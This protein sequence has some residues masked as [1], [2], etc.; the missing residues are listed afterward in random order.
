MDLVSSKIDEI[1]TFDKSTVHRKEIKDQL[2]NS[3]NHL[4]DKICYNIRYL[5]TQ[6][7]SNLECSRRIILSGG[8]TLIEGLKDTVEQQL[9]SKVIQP[10][11]P[12][13]SNVYGFYTMGVKLYG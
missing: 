2:H 13:F 1:T 7:P 12:I 9:D 10:S 11:D 4:T 5:L 8:G 6:L 3:V